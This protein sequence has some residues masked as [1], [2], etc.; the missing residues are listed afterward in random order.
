M[1]LCEF[2]CVFVC[3]CRHVYVFKC[4]IC[5]HACQELLSVDFYCIVPRMIR[6][7]AAS[8][9][10]SCIPTGSMRESYPKIGCC[11][12]IMILLSQAK[13]LICYAWW[14]LA[15]SSLI[16]WGKTSAGQSLH[17]FMW[18]SV[19][20]SA[21]HDLASQWEAVWWYPASL[22]HSEDYVTN[23]PTGDC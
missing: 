14:R 13:S 17:P 1:C 6:H 15:I 21:W 5:M 3:L 23:K 22:F 20:I 2:L 16:E 18:C 7:D 12:D 10:P 11:C 4:Y 8:V 9:P 19:P